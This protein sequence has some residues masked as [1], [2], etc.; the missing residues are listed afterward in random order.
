MRKILLSALLAFLFSSLQPPLAAQDFKLIVNDS[1]PV[2]S[3]SKAQAAR[4][5]LK[6]STTWGD[7][8]TVQPVDRP[9]SSR[10]RDT[11]SRTVL[12]KSVAAVKS[13]WQ[14]QIFSGNGVPPLELRSEEEIISYVRSS[15]GAIGYVSGGAPTN[16]VKVIEV[17][18]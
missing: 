15:S 10:V 9:D 7:G 8:T 4:F 5:F 18:N 17:T 2:S 3:I 13:Y 12:G 14:Q 16:G 6:K 11:F 1:I